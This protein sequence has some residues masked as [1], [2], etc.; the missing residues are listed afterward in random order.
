MFMCSKQNILHLFWNYE[1]TWICEKIN[2][3]Q[4]FIHNLNNYVPQ[5]VYMLKVKLVTMTDPDAAPSIFLG[6]S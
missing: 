5:D 1:Y 4:N 3:F 2:D 6:F